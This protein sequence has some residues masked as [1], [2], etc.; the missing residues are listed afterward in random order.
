M[1]IT[2]FSQGIIKGLRAVSTE[3]L[4]VCF[5]LFLVFFGIY[6]TNS[7][8]TLPEKKIISEIEVLKEELELNQLEGK[9]YYK[10][11]AFEGYGV[12]FYPD[13]SLA[14]KIGYYQGK[15]EGLAQKWY[16]NQALRY[17]AHYRQNRKHGKAKAW[18]PQG[19]LMLEAN[20]VEG[21]T[22]GIQ[23]QWYASGKPFKETNFNMGREEGIQRGWLESGG[24][25]ANY[26]AKNGRFFGLKRANACY[27]L[28]SEVIQF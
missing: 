22:H 8:K 4:R 3:G 10:G 19:I 20:F 5:L 14:E 2:S 25:F 21:L 11:K 27:A 7:G 15:K 23:R 1:P 6:F 17:E 9:W 24:L 26:E 18:S 12:I 16:P 13:G 28:K